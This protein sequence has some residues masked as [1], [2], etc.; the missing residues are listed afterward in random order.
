MRL[1]KEVEGRTVGIARQNGMLLTRKPLYLTR[2]SGTQPFDLFL[3]VTDNKGSEFLRR[4][5]NPAHNNFEFDR[6]NDP[7]ER[8]IFKSTYKSFAEDIREF[9]LNFAAIDASDEA[10]T[11]DLDDF[12][13]ALDNDLSSDLGKEKSNSLLIEDRGVSV[14]RPTSRESG[15]DEDDSLV[16]PGDSQNV[17]K[18]GK[19]SR[20]GDK[21]LGSLRS[22]Q[23][24]EV[25][26]PRIIKVGTRK[27]QVFF[28]PT[29]KSAFWLKLFRSGN[30][31]NDEIH[32]RPDGAPEFKNEVF[33]PA[34]SRIRRESLI[35]ELSADDFGYA[36]EIV[37][38]ILRDDK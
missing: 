16:T 26:D 19:S 18:G 14:R 36:I 4:L 35:V 10:L 33:F 13:G 5:E 30:Q 32:F 27:A 25:I 24:Q 23:L 20:A 7:E 31:V 3:C 12:L 22:R 2:F 28:T 21:L 29:T 34:R 17:T 38:Q 15:F 6:I 8:R 9:I 1:G 37:S 11:D